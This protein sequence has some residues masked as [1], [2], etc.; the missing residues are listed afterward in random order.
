MRAQRLISLVL[1]LQTRGPLSAEA[2]AG[3][4]ESSVRT[5]HRDVDALRAAGIP[6]RGD[7]G[8]AGGFRLPG[9]YRTRLTGLTPGEA[10]ALFLQAPAADLGLGA[11]LGDAQLKL[12]AALPPELRAR[13][14]RTAELFHVVRDGW[15]GSSAPPVHLVTAADA[16]WRGRRLTITHRGYERAIDPLGLVHKGRSWYLVAGTDRG[17]RVF[18][19]DRLEAA[20]VL[21]DEPAERPRDFD[22][23][24]F[25]D[26]W[27][28]S[29]ERSLPLIDVRVRVEPEALDLLRR[30][31]DTRVR[32]ALPAA[33]DEP[34]E[35]VVGFERL[36]YA[37]WGLLPI[38]PGVEVLSPPELRERMATVSAA[39]A[40]RYLSA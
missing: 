40:A 10:E 4:L 7:R 5:V 3:E 32:D 36:A 6:I 18:R 2:L 23:P 34:T 26:E 30:A 11:V 13:A 35:I 19:A 38:G 9:G 12:L 39:T 14:D 8:P 20:A 37:E 33:I 16:L 15:W 17:L 24:T 27:S 21:P 29:F 25:F 31:V 22:L 28:V 1:L